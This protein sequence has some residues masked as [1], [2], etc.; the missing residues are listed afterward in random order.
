MLRACFQAI[1][2]DLGSPPSKALRKHLPTSPTETQSLLNHS[3]L[4]LLFPAPLGEVSMI[5]ML[6]R[7]G[8]LRT[9]HIWSRAPRPPFPPPPPK[10]KCPDIGWGPPS[11]VVWGVGSLFPLWGGCGV[12]RFRV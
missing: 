7:H 12:L 3:H 10:V 11:P 4:S 9:L 1:Y 8:N 5:K 2:A 6:D